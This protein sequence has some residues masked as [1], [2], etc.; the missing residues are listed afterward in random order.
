MQK[1]GILIEEAKRN[2][3]TKTTKIIEE[4]LRKSWGNVEEI[5]RRAMSVK[6]TV[7]TNIVFHEITRNYTKKERY[8]YIA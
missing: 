2:K 3:N 5:E 7:Q 1:V 6:K 4:M 8:E